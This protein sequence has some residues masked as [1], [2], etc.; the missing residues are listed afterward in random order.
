[1]TSKIR[2]DADLVYRLAASADLSAIRALIDASV[3]G[4]GPQAYSPSQI[5]QALGKWLGLDTQLVADQTYFVVGPADA[6]ETLAACGGWSRRRTPFG[7]DARPGRDDALLDPRVDAAKIRAFFVHPEWAR[8]GIGS[9]L[10]AL[11]EEAA[12]AEGFT[13]CE[14]GATLTGIPLY[15]R[16]GYVEGERL[17]L[18][19]ADGETLAIVKMGKDL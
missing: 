6:P 16:H 3:R 5:E 15:R 10:L 4:L 19:L 1:M 7:A 12:R 9:H 2:N 14:M 11:C 18:P 8:Q 13:R 17:E